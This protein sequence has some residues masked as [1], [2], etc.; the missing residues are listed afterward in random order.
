MY[1][2]RYWILCRKPALSPISGPYAGINPLKLP[3]ENGISGF[4]GPKNGDK[5]NI[6]RL[7]APKR[8]IGLD[9][10]S[11][12]DANEVQKPQLKFKFRLKWGLSSFPIAKKETACAKKRVRG[13]I[14]AFE[15]TAETAV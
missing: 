9:F 6:D 3:G 1:G 14:I 7:S 15:A 12:K 4:S 13:K 2:Q 10:S 8:L 5:S 11:C